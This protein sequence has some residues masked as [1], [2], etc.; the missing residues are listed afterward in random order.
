M[1]V[2]FTGTQHGLTLAQREALRACLQRLPVEQFHHGDCI[3]AD[4]T[5]HLFMLNKVPIVIHPSNHKSKRAYCQGACK[6]HP[7]RPPLER[8]RTIVDSVDLLVACPQN[9]FEEMRSGTWATI[10]AAIKISKPVTIIWPDG[11]QSDGLP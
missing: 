7:P 10:R 1:K 3:G 8:N 5:A 9:M 6:V 2:G 4:S 11:T